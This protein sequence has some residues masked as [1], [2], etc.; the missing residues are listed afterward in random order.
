M[1]KNHLIPSPNS[2]IQGLSYAPAA[3]A[4]GAC[5]DALDLFFST[6]DAL[7]FRN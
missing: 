1:L 6:Q 5:D 4:H 7:D 2:Q 3:S